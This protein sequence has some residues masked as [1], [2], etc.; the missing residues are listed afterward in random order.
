MNTRTFFAA[1][2]HFGHR[3]V[4]TFTNDDGSLMRPFDTIEEHDEYLVQQ[5]NKVVR[6]NDK[7][8]HLG[9]VVMNRS[10]LHIVQRLNGRKVLVKGNHDIFTAREY[11]DA[12]FEDIQGAVVF[13]SGYL[14]SHIPVHDCQ[15]E[16]WRV[17]VHGHLHNNRSLDHDPRYVC[18][19]MERLPD[20]SPVT[21]DWIQ[22]EVESRN[23]EVQ[24]FNPSECHFPE[25]M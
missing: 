22:T 5:W 25:P 3:R 8:Y 12:G 16:R 18:V 23:F 14:L 6:P 24:E 21:W 17:N 10:S 2:T 4:I 20:W 15:L 11:L 13:K 7:V 19:S 1:D 9:D